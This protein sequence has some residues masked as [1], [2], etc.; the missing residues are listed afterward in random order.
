MD[1]LH[2][3]K[4]VWV[5]PVYPSNHIYHCLSIGGT[6]VAGWRGLSGKLPLK[7]R[8][9]ADIRITFYMMNRRSHLSMNQSALTNYEGD[10]RSL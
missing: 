6:P 2:R 10:H 3:L 5:K 4:H 7:S 1:Q 9:A 8:A